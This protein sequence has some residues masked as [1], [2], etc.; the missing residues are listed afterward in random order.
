MPIVLTKMDNEILIDSSESFKIK[1]NPSSL[2]IDE[3]GFLFHDGP[4]RTGGVALIKSPGLAE[5]IYSQLN[6]DSEGELL[7]YQDIPVENSKTRT[8]IS[9]LKEYSLFG[10]HVEPEL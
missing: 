8:S 5:E 1:F 9:I 3:N 6:I 7:S 4:E 10:S 2:L